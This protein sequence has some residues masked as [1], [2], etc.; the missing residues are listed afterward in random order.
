M[1]DRL[2]QFAGIRTDEQ[3]NIIGD[4]LMI[5][6]KP[7][8]DF[9]PNPDSCL[10]TGITPQ[11][12]IE[13]G[14]PEAE[15]ITQIHNEFSQPGTCVLGYNNLR[16]DDEFTRYSLYRNLFDPY[17]REWQNGNSRWDLLD[18]VR[19][20]RAL[21]PEGVNW[22]VNEEQRPSVRLEELTVANNIEHTSA[23]D[24][25]SDVY[26]TIALAKLIKEK[27]PKLFEYAYENRGKNKILKMLNMRE[28]RPVIHV[29]GMYPVEQGNMAVVI[30]V[31]PHPT[32]KNAVIVYDISQDPEPLYKL[33]YKEIHKRIFTPTAELPEGVERLPLKTVQAN[34]CPI[35]VPFTTLDATAA[36]KY[37]IDLNRCRDHMEFIKHQPPLINKLHKVFSETNFEKRTNPDQMLYGGPFFSADDK[38]CMEK[39]RGMTPEELRD[40]EP[41]FTD[42]RLPEMLFR[43]RARNYPESLTDEET[44]RWNE[45][46]LAR[47]HNEAEGI[48]PEALKKL[49]AER[50]DSGELSEKQLTI[51]SRLEEYVATL[52][53]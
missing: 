22:P 6:C 4:P 9:I 11:E 39:I 17:A 33:G 29:S 13:K 19:L 12:A 40:Y 14:L 41:I 45:F 52:I 38:K 43:Y 49:V 7:A 18:V 46:R 48:T 21:R 32:N 5:Y 42:Q 2:V 1:H 27:Q 31:A 26:A 8:N 47:L 53:Q 23:H 16:F 20:T 15:F 34:K 37:G 10:I 44:A 25:L 36:K 35:I 3:L 24:A 30:P 28:Q 51:L 50:R